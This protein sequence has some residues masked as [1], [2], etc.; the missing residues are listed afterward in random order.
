M[1]KLYT[2]S[3]RHRGHALAGNLRY[4]RQEGAHAFCQRLKRRGDFFDKEKAVVAEAEENVTNRLIRVRGLIGTTT[5]AESA[6]AYCRYAAD[7]LG[8]FTPLADEDR[9][10]VRGISYH[11]IINC[12]GRYFIIRVKAP[13]SERMS[14]YIGRLLT[15]KPK[16]RE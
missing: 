10:V 8:S 11:M 14:L 6:R 12:H 15:K 2:A 4:L 7:K 13:L 3:H 1:R 16:Y 9:K 5:D